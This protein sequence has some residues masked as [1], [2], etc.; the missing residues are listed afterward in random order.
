MPN[1][2][3]N[4]LTIQ[5]PREQ[6]DSIKNRLNSPFTRDHENWDMQSQSMQTKTYTYSNPVFSFWNICKPDD[7]DAY[8][9]Q[10]EHNPNSSFEDM[11]K[12]DDWYSW[13]TRNWGT[14]WDVSVS[15]DDKYP[16]TE[17]IEDMNNGEDQ[18]LVYRFNTAWSPPHPAVQKLSALVP[19]CVVTLDYEEETG[20]GGETEFVKGKETAH[21]DYESKC[22]DCDAEDTLDYCDND[23]GQICS[24]CNYLGEADLDCVKECQTHKIYLD[25]EHVP[26]YRM[27]QING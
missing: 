6:L 16:D 14:K 27:E 4:T 13:N 8:M 23:C 5:G 3:Y 21:S 9:K 25:S 22:R 19:N 18:W 24:A 12:G 26:D 7:L 10:P 11:F 2:C 17:L 1:W 15:D 20:W